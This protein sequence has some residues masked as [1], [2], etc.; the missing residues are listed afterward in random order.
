MNDALDS[1]LARWEEAHQRGESLDVDQLCAGRPELAD[2]LRSQI[3]A[4]LRIGGM[5]EST[6]DEPSRPDGP[7]EPTLLPAVSEYADLRFHARGGLGEVFLARDATLGREVAVKLIQP[8]RARDATLHRRFLHEAEITGRLEHPGIVPVYGRGRDAGSRPYY[9]MKRIEGETL[10]EAIRRFHS[11]PGADRP[12]PTLRQL[13]G[14]FTAAC[15]AIDYAHSRGVLHRDIK[16]ANIMLGPFEETLVVDWGLAR[17]FRDRE[18]TANAGNSS[19]ESQADG[20]TRPGSAMGTPGYVS[21]EQATGRLD[22]VGP[23]SDVYSLGATLY[24]ILTGS[25]PFQGEP[26][27]I[28]KKV[29]YGVFHKPRDRDPSIDPALEAIVLKAMAKSAAD[30]Y[31][32]CRALADDI[33][34]WLADERVSAYREPW[35]RSLNR[36]LAKHRTVVTGAAAA[37][38]MLMAGLAAVAVVQTRARHDMDLKN[39][40]LTEL[41]AALEVQ[42][43]RAEERE[44]QAI[45]AVKRFRDA[46]A[47]NPELKDNPSLESLRKALLKEPLSFFGGLRE[48]MQADRDMRPESLA[49]LAGVIH[50]YAHL[51]DEI[52]DPS[53]GLKAHVDCLAIWEGLARDDPNRERYQFHLAAILHCR[54][55]FL[56]TAGRVAEALES[57]ERARTIRARLAEDHPNVAQYQVHLADSYASNGVLLSNAGRA[58]EAL[59]PHERARTILARLAEDHPNV[60]EYQAH[61][62]DSLNNIGVLLSNAGRAAEALESHERARSIRARLAE[63]HPTVAG[64]QARLADSHNNIGLLLSNAGRAAEALESYQR[65]RTI[66]AWLAEDRPAVAEY[67]ARLVTSHN[68]IGALQ[69]NTGLTAEAL[70]SHERARTIGERLVLAYPESPEYASDFGGTL[71]NVATIKMDD[72]RWTEA[73][74]LLLEAVSWQKKAVAAD[75]RRAKF[76][77]YL[78]NHLKNW[79]VTARRLGLSDEATEVARELSEFRASDPKFAPLDARLEAIRRGESAKDN[80]ERL[81]LAQRAYDVRR[82]DEAAKLW[83]EALE[84]DPK[85]A[86]SRK[87]QHRYNAACAAALA[88]DG[89]GVDPPD[90]G[91]A[92]AELRGNALAWLRSERDAW[93]RILESGQPQAGAVVVQT[94]QH[95]KQDADLASIRD[96]IE[97]LP[98]AERAAWRSLW[99]E[100]DELLKKAQVP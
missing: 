51:T 44:G 72:L 77:R 76:R 60:A 3:G 95:W 78:E 33:D 15:H 96:R 45:D 25:A 36:W 68:N 94:L 42:R 67:Q 48:R 24:A 99:A 46:V 59:E 29:E 70:E 61:L 79:I 22:E 74:D 38:I 62:A 84:S 80:A 10:Q 17:S 9:V 4:L 89:Q 71:N 90:D 37:G 12:S 86:E 64:Y 85:L 50:D 1:L 97:Q 58:A 56:R 83:G 26:A 21:P 35:T 43:N 28:L 20:A 14:R 81:S 66:F 5:I 98:E 6:Q 87:P 32:S 16:P 7:S 69:R 55:Q 23:A 31:E 93:S 18:S 2:A 75:A 30:R 65:A 57:Y 11:G 47:D 52:G 53:D 27:A 100:V 39:G 88:A 8:R 49:R 41:N 40:E 82:P 34:R 13:L 73:R 19:P 91:A 54:G 92:K 63:G